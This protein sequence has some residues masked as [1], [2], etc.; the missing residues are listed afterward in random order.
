MKTSL[1]KPLR[2]HLR[3]ASLSLALLCILCS[4]GL[5]ESHRYSPE[6]A[7][8]SLKF[9]DEVSPYR[10]MSV[11]V[12]PGEEVTFEALD[13]D[14]EKHYE[15]SVPS[16]MMREKSPN[17][18]IWSAP[19]ETGL[20]SVRIMNPESSE[21]MK[22]NV[23]VMFPYNRL[24][25]EY[26]NGYRIG[27]YPSFPSRHISLYKNPK[28]FIEV[29]RENEETF[30]SPHFRL[31]QFLCKQGGGYPKYIVLKERLLLKLELIL[32]HINQEG[33]T[34][35]TFHVLSGYRTPYYNKM[36][37]NVPYSRHLFGGAADIFID[38]DPKDGL[39]DD[40]NKDRRINYL[41][42]QVIYKII[43]DLYGRPRYT[44][45]AGG[46]GWYKKTASHGPFVHID[47]RGYRAR[48]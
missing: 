23:F 33:Y 18:W 27:T 47:V 20:Y 26:L 28:G 16:G 19:A 43:D 1:G 39:M 21:S 40:L 13:K 38:E 42:A 30:V 36:I 45:F 3:R 31:K 7:S 44:L 37:G 11:F 4:V 41:D 8:F 48:W 9:K 2:T 35:D 15:W 29:T 10:I 17:K 25:G 5:S 6:K 32:E 14:Q 34:A 12:L 46:L 22:I 24:E